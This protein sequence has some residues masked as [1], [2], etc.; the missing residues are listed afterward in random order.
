MP[1]PIK[2]TDTTKIQIVKCPKIVL[3]GEDKSAHEPF[4]SYGSHRGGSNRDNKKIS[5]RDKNIQERIR[6][7]TQFDTYFSSVSELGHSAL[8]GQ[9]RK[10]HK[11]DKLTSLGVRPEKAQTM[12]FKMKM[13][14]LT[15][16]EKRQK[17]I[18]NEAKQSGLVLSARAL[19]AKV[20]VASLISSDGRG[21]GVVEKG[22][23]NP[24]ID[25]SV[26]GGVLRMPKGDQKWDKGHGRKGSGRGRGKGRR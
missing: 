24:D 11:S 14:I 1:K 17:R 25:V 19:G 9:A 21:K 6:Q 4:K 15:G 26:R 22:S 23:F 16:K 20:S 5:E 7:R 3:P 18:L 2:K 10:S 8:T 13:G 12:P